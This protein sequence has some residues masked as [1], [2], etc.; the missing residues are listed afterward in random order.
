MRAGEVQSAR[1]TYADQ[2]VRR[3][4]VCLG[5]AQQDVGS[6]TGVQSVVRYF[7]RLRHSEALNDLFQSFSAWAQS[8]DDTVR[9]KPSSSAPTTWPPRFSKP[10][11]PGADRAGHRTCSAADR[12]YDQHACRAAANAEPACDARAQARCRPGRPDPLNAGGSVAI[13]QLHRDRAGRRVGLGAVERPD[14]ARGR[15]PAVSFSAQVCAA[16]FAPA[17]LRRCARLVAAVRQRRRRIS[18]TKPR[19]DNWARC[20]TPAIA[21]CRHISAMPSSRAT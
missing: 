7:R 9:G 4:M 20:S 21:C 10:P 14:S 13:R 2:A 3:Q 17:G 19:R 5:Q 18:R 16:G 6:L 8:P 11:Q 12:R 15:R 1:S